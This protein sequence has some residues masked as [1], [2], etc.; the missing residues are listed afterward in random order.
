[1]RKQSRTHKGKGLNLE[2]WLDREEEKK[3][4]GERTL[5]INEMDD[6]L[7]IYDTDGLPFEEEGVFNDVDGMTASPSEATIEK[8]LGIKP[9]RYAG[10]PPLTISEGT[11][12]D[13]L[14]GVTDYHEAMMDNIAMM[15]EGEPVWSFRDRPKS[16]KTIHIQSFKYVQ[17]LREF[18]GINKK[19]VYERRILKAKI[20]ESIKDLPTKLAIRFFALGE[21]DKEWFKGY[22]HPKTYDIIKGRAEKSL[23]LADIK[24]RNTGNDPEPVRKKAI[25]YEVKTLWS[26]N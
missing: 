21:I 17:Q 24:Y 13:A 2:D 7:P 23:K 14:Y 12:K 25:E 8:A 26:G 10:M 22:L 5:P 9:S 11:L 16:Q 4:L 20:T 15:R 18:Y 6:I 19:D 3:Q 1:M